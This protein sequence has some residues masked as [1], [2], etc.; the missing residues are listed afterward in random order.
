MTMRLFDGDVRTASIT[1]CAP[2]PS[3]TT[4]AS[5]FSLRRRSAALPVT[6]T[7]SMP[8][9]RKHSRQNG[10]VAVFKVDQGNR[11]PQLSWLGGWGPEQFQGHCP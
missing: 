3:L 8:N 5:N 10:A 4:Q 1:A 2:G 9:C 6:M 11:G 7:A